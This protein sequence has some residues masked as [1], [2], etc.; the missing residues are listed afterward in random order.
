[1]GI[2]VLLVDDEKEFIDALAQRLELRGYDVQIAYSGIEAIGIITEKDVDVIV[3]DIKMPGMEGIEALG[4]IKALKPGI[5]V[6]MLTAHGSLSEAMTA[7]KKDA[8]D[9]IMKPAPID[10]IIDKITTAYE[11]KTLNEQR[12]KAGNKKKQVGAE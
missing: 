12:N 11:V 3:L 9:F 2:K 5:E 7:M 8:H 6:V 1:M 10:V 4:K